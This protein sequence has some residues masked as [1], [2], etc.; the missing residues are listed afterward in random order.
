MRKRVQ[1]V[2]QAKGKP[3]DRQALSCVPLVLLLCCSCAPLVLPLAP[4]GVF[5][6]TAAVSPS[7]RVGLTA[8]RDR[9][10]K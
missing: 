1:C 4:R 2:V 5:G 10:F 8:L 7:P 6:G 3:G 9:L